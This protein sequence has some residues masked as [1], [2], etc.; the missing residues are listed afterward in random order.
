[1]KINH[2]N[3]ILQ[4]PLSPS[5]FMKKLS[6]DVPKC[7]NKL[8]IPDNKFE[9]LS[10]KDYN[11]ILKYNYSIPQL[12]KICRHHDQKVSGNKSA[13]QTRIYNY[14]RLSN[15]IVKIQRLVRLYFL[16]KYNALK[17]PAKFNRE[18]CVNDTDFF[19]MDDVKNIPYKLFI[20]IK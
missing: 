13:L 10:I 15:N 20:S 2:E 19:S 5:S 9:L 8:K 1:M 3:Q 6:Y 7:K 14:L 17:G 18:L 4:P 11:N 16:K 12:K